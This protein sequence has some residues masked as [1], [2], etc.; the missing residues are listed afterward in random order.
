[1]W[2]AEAASSF[3]VQR[4]ARQIPTRHP[5]SPMSVSTPA[6]AAR[7]SRWL[8]AV[9][10]AGLAAGTLDILAAFVQSS[11]RGNGPQVVL[12]AV[13]SGVLGREAFRRGPEVAALGL[14]LHFIIALGWAALYYLASRRLP[15]LVRRPVLSGVLYGV[16]VFWLMRLVVVPLSA[17]PK[18]P[19]SSSLLG[20]A[21]PIGIHILFVGLPISLAVAW[22]VGKA[23]VMLPRVE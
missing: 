3:G 16:L 22:Q 14:L 4:R 11:V 15:V 17:A 8:A 1:V 19:G 21:V 7:P 18:F 12:K 9:L 6:Y 13:T 23:G 10:T 20:L 5:E 2:L